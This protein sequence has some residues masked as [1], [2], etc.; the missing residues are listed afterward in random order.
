MKQEFN[1]KI[2]TLTEENISRFPYIYHYEG[3]TKLFGEI[4]GIVKEIEGGLEE[5]L[6]MFASQGITLACA[7]SD[8]SSCRSPYISDS[9]GQVVYYLN[10]WYFEGVPD[11]AKVRLRHSL[12]RQY[13]LL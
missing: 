8:T 2:A 6:A 4:N 12:Q 1:S 13:Q 10:L 3:H 7:K 9:A 11:S 5:A